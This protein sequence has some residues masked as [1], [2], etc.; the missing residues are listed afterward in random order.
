[1]GA[2]I[3]NIVCEKDDDA[4]AAIRALKENKAGRLTFPACRI[5]KGSQGVSA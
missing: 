3:Q 1:M 4:K 5:H 2:S